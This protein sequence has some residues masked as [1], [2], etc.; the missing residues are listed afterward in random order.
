M[1]EFKSWLESHEI[2][3]RKRIEEMRRFPTYV[4]N[5]ICNNEKFYI[6]KISGCNRIRKEGQMNI[7]ELA[8]LSSA[9][10][11]A[12]VFLEIL[13]SLEISITVSPSL[14]FLRSS[15]TESFFSFAIL[16]CAILLNTIA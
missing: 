16:F 5:I 15:T 1:S 10:A 9:R 11:T 8:P 13:S 7:I 4:D 6:W 14:F 3:L 12:T 2:D